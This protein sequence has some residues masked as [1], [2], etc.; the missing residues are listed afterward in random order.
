MTAFKLCFVITYILSNVDSTQHKAP[1]M[2]FGFS[3]TGNERLGIWQVLHVTS[4]SLDVDDN[5]KDTSAN[6]LASP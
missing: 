2:L 6:S 4:S 1:E 5:Y 3:I